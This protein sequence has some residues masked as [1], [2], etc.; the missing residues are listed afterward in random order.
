MIAT[1]FRHMLVK[2]LDKRNETSIIRFMRIPLKTMTYVD[3][4]ISAYFAINLIIPHL[5]R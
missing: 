1:E 3:N 5:Y 2:H 4:I